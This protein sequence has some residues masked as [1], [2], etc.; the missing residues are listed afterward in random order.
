MSNIRVAWLDREKN[1]YDYASWHKREKIKQT[2]EWV[3]KQNLLYPHVFYWI[4]EKNKQGILVNAVNLKTPTN[5]ETNN[6]TNNNTN[7]DT[8]NETNYE[9]YVIID[10]DSKF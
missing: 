1:K 6:E 2:E 9:N 8:N 5:N 4:E 10:K 3:T 7:N